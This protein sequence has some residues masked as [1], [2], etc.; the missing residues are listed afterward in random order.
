MKLIFKKYMWVWLLD[1]SYQVKKSQ[2]LCLAFLWFFCFLCVFY[3][4]SINDLASALSKVRLDPNT[5][6]RICWPKD[7]CTLLR[8]DVVLVDRLINGSGN[9]S[10]VQRGTDHLA[11]GTWLELVIGLEIAFLATWCK[12]ALRYGG[13][14]PDFGRMEPDQI[15][16]SAFLD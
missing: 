8:D 6:I 11:R 16:A 1:F 13:A 15:W 9:S 14:T 10:L 3:V 12:V 5:L 4:Q 2:T 7:L